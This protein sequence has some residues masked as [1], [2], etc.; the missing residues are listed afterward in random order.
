MLIVE[1]LGRNI[2]MKDNAVKATD[3]YNPCKTA[4]LGTQT[5][6]HKDHRYKLAILV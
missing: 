5:V 6:I 1:S 3:D 2:C 4:Q